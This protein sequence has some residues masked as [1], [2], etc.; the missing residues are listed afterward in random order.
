MTLPINKQN[1]I[2]QMLKAGVPKLQISRKLNVAYMTIINYANKSKG[3][4]GKKLFKK[5]SIERLRELIL[6]KRDFNWISNLS[7]Q[8][9]INYAIKFTLKKKGGI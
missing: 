5:T 6:N 8:D 3:K 4:K 1:K 9:V 2:R 7:D